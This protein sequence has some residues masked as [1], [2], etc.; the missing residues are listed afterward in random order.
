MNSKFLNIVLVLALAGL[1]GCASMSADE[2]LTVDWATIGFEDGSRG[3]TADRLG[4]HR[5]AC[6]KHGVAADLA[7]YQ[8]GHAQGIEAFCQPG[9]GFNFGVNGGGY[10][11]VCP[12]HLEQEFLE[13]YSA[14]HKLYSLRSSLN[15]ANSLIHSKEAEIDSAEKRIAAAQLEMI[16]DESTSEQRVQLL[17]ELKE[18]AE[19]VGELEAE[20]KQ[21]VADRARIEQELQY[22]ESTLTAYGY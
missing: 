5:K 11:G 16:S 4:T 2:C 15:T 14:G 7:A 6:A 13:A 3:Y 18:L 22:Y 8:R 1:S 12:A 10:R 21:L 20:I 19:R 9:R 17:V